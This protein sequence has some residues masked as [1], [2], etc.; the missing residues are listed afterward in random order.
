MPT[1]LPVR[2][3][4]SASYDHLFEFTL[5]LSQFYLIIAMAAWIAVT[6]E[7]HFG[8]FNGMSLIEAILTATA[9]DTPFVG[10]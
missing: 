2:K 3:A 6:L 8:A 4:A 1:T 9:T 10:P 5:M 7:Y